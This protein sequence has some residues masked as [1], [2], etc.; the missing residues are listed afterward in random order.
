MS[1]RKILMVVAGVALVLAYGQQVS[2]HRHFGL[3]RGNGESLSR[4]ARER[5]NAAILAGASDEKI[6]T[7]KADLAIIE[8]A[9]GKS[10]IVAGSPGTAI[11]G[12]AARAETNPLFKSS[13]Q[14]AEEQRHEADEHRKVAQHANKNEP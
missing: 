7:A 10:N 11:E 4:V 9:H 2:H 1:K 5:L 12:G 14:I 8:S 6:E 3:I 13:R